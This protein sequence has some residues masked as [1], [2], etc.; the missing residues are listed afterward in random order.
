MDHA[1][2]ARP[3]IDRFD[4]FFEIGGYNP[5]F[6]FIFGVPLSESNACI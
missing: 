2:Y 4:V 5:T 1:F 6:L 3:C